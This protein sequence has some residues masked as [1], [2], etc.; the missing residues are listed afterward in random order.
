MIYNKRR[1]SAIGF[2]DMKQLNWKVIKTN[3]YMDWFQVNDYTNT[4]WEKLNSTSL[5]VWKVFSQKDW[6]NLLAS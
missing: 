2:Y 5:G 3:P 4:G 6:L 1:I